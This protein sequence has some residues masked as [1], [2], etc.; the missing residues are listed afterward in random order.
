MG[1]GQAASMSRVSLFAAAGALALI[2][3]AAHA[4]DAAADSETKD[5][6]EVV[7]TAAPYVVSLDSTTTSVKSSAC[8]AP[9]VNSSKAF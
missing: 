4:A 5:L 1:S 9:A 6:S 3:S 8:S 7:V 2:A